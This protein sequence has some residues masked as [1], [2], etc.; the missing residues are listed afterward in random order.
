M[1]GAR[2]AQFPAGC[3]TRFEVEEK[4]V[5]V[6]NVKQ[7]FKAAVRGGRPGPDAFR[8]FAEEV[9]GEQIEHPCLV[10]ALHGELGK[11]QVTPVEEVVH[12]PHDD[13]LAIGNFPQGRNGVGVEGVVEVG[14][15]LA[16]V[17]EHE[18]ILD[19]QALDEENQFEEFILQNRKGW[20]KLFARGRGEVEGFSQV[21]AQ[22]RK[23]RQALPFLRSQLFTAHHPYYLAAREG[24]FH[25]FQ[26]CHDTQAL[27]AAAQIPDAIGSQHFLQVLQHAVEAIDQPLNISRKERKVLPIVFCLRRVVDKF[28]PAPGSLKFL[29]CVEHLRQQERGVEENLLVVNAVGRIKIQV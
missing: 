4:V 7:R 25:C 10:H 3:D 6:V 5:V 22:F 19:G 2:E 29:V 1:D 11:Q 15:D 13:G 23:G 21:G 26:G 20:L 16:P 14:V 9:V 18:P 24:R 8:F 27:Q 28:I 12:I 17:I